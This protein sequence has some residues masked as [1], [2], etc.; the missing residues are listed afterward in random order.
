MADGALRL[1]R[2]GIYHVNTVTVLFSRNKCAVADIF[3]DS[4]F[5]DEY[6]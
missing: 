5:P 6:P 3:V 1:S 4:Y 2:F